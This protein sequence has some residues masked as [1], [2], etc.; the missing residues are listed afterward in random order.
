MLTTAPARYFHTISPREL[1]LIVF[2]SGKKSPEVKENYV[3][4][5]IKHSMHY[6]SGHIL[7]RREI[8]NANH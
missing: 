6:R 4:I 1:I 8:I 7:K 3:L 5:P 2:S